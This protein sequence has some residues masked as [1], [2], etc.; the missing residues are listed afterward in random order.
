M[1]SDHPTPRPLLENGRFWWLRRIAIAIGVFVV[2]A[3]AGFWISRERIAGNMI[4]DALA[5]S[6]LT[7]EYDIVSI[8]P[9]TQVIE[10]LVI[11]DPARPDLTIERIVAEVDYGWGAPQLGRVTAIHPRI[12]GLYQDGALSFG[13]L[14]PALFGDGEQGIPALDVKVVD[15]RGLIESDYG[16]IALKLD[17]EG[18]LD[19]GFTGKLAATAPGIGPEGCTAATATAFGEL[20]MAAGLPEFSGPVRLG[21]AACAGVTLGSIDMTAD[22]ST[23]DDFSKL[24]SALTL[25]GA[26]IAFADIAGET[27]IGTAQLTVDGKAIN[28]AHDIAINSLETSYGGLKAVQANGS[29]RSGFANGDTEW[30]ADVT[31]QDFTP[32]T[33]ATGLMANAKAGVRGTLFAPLL[34]KLTR[35]LDAQTK[36][37]TLDASVTVRNNESG[38]AIIIPEGRVTNP[39]GDPLLALSRVSWAPGGASREGALTGNFIT[40]GTGLPQINGRMEQ[41]GRG[42]LQ[43]RMAMADYADGTNRFGL[44]QFRLEQSRG[45]DIRFSGVVDASGEIPGGSVSRLSLPIKGMLS[46]SG[47]L[48]IGQQCMAARFDALEFYDLMLDART[49]RLC[50]EPGARS[51]V[52]FKDALNVAIATDDLDFTGRL[53]GSPVRIASEGLV[54]R[55]PAPFS[56]TGVAMRIGNEGNGVDLY[57]DRLEGAF[58]TQ[59]GEPFISGMFDGG[60]AGIDPVPLNFTDLAGN[61]RYDDAALLVDNAAITVS[62]RT[63]GL[64][65]FNP[66]SA[67]DAYFTLAG[68]DITANAN[69]RHPA[70]VQT[71]TS[72]DIVHDLNSGAGQ[73]F[74]NVAGVTFGE[75]FEPED[76]SELAKGVIALAEGTVSGQGQINWTEDDVKSTGKFGTR[77][78]DFA[79]DFGPV[80]GMSGDIVFTDLLN[81]T[82]APDQEITI[83]SVNPGIEVLAGNIRYAMTN[84]EVIAIFDARWPFMGGELTLGA[85]DIRLYQPED[86]NALGA[87]EQEF[88]FKI[89]GLDASKFVAQLELTNLRA[90]G[91]FDGTI[92]IVFDADG[93]GRIRDGTLTARA[94]G[95]NLAYVGEL[96]YEDMGAMANFAFQSLRSLDYTKM[97]IGL[98]GD[99][100]GEIITH[101]TFD[102][103]SQGEGT[104]QNFVT[105][106]LAKLPIRFKVNVRSQNFYQLT[107][108]VRSFWDPTLI[109]DPLNRG[110]LPGSNGQL[111]VQIPENKDKPSLPDPEKNDTDATIGRKDESAV[112]LRESEDIL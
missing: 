84:G 16:A 69:L 51:M 52:A 3:G 85:T 29:L 33:S 13:A 42:P 37:A 36:G 53:G 45:G 8:G 18:M 108:M 2:F 57:A 21:N 96:L 34:E 46:R 54:V 87:G 67:A 79:A 80:E 24:V 105:K 101:L 71:I 86:L 98:N 63:D 20:T 60:M 17:G 95:G 82:T 4:D 88:V 35:N 48:A 92:P 12:Y 102:G 26:Q 59:P 23:N 43:M 7:A 103:V 91:T 38:L 27:L 93:N 44:P 66:L 6:G 62:E 75:S 49:L 30:N 68:S 9:Q 76:V 19:D 50:P 110:T 40:G 58:G 41:R 11:G 81:L 61:W 112:Q 70:S 72:V 109:G 73:A 94:P 56:L 32:G 111:E 78:F 90:S 5:E 55:Y 104:S 31:G 64:P 47:A 74:L 10:N 83:A 65:R 1:E 14:D 100:A 15:A 39:T 106:R 89:D 25:A 99:L 28:L 77:D 97:S 107:T 22:L